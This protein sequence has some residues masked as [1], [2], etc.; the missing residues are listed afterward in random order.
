MHRLEDDNYIRNGIK[1]HTG[2][3]ILYLKIF[4]NPKMSKNT[5]ER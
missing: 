4:K 2:A 1:V 5:F 3:D